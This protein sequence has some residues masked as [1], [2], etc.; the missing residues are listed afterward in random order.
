MGDIQY[1]WADP[2][3][4]QQQVAM[5]SIVQAM[6]EK[7]SVAITRW[8][9]KDGMDAKMGILYPE[10]FEKV[11]CF[12]W[13]QVLLVHYSNRKMADSPQMPFAD[14]V[15]RYTFTSLDK[16]ISRSGEVI[17]KHPYIPTETQQDAMDDFVD[18]MDLM[19]AGDKDEEG[20]TKFLTLL[21]VP[22]S[23]SSD[24][25]PWFNPAQSYNPSIHR[26]KQ[27]MFHCAV[28]SD[29]A[30]NPLPPP[31]PELLKYFTAP[32][33]VLERARSS[34]DKCKDEFKIKEVPKSTSRGGA[35]RREHELA[36]IEDDEMLL[37]DR[38][39]E[40]LKTNAEKISPMKVDLNKP[41][42]ESSSDGK[43]KAKAVNQDDSET[44]DD[45]ED[46]ITVQIPV[47][48]KSGELSLNSE[49]FPATPNFSS[50]HGR[51]LPIS[52]CPPSPYIDP[53][54]APGRVIGTT[55]PLEDFEKY[56]SQGKIVSKAVSDLFEVIIEILMKPF[57]SRRHEEM[58]ECMKALRDICLKVSLDNHPQGGLDDDFST[59]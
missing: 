10:V 36:A 11:E 16:L 44:E 9:S 45:E 58:I 40:S 13:T 27:A 4:P 57:A 18:T 47:D 54:R 12:L 21:V 24:R 28:V 22:N 33:K 20:Y 14:D 55:Y 50:Q 39:P 17:T 5:S 41:E 46:Y 51:P 37:L 34:I 31:H 19:T 52:S 42:F 35:V 59:F 38:K 26:I 32:T 8:V 49:K 2:S 3:S 29:I 25:M 23:S 48:D 43:G 53:G 7:G 1:I 56:L 6:Y 30:T 15:H